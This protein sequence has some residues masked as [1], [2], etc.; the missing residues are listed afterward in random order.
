MDL[1]AGLST[2][3]GGYDSISMVVDKLTKVTHLIPVKKTFSASDIA[4]VFVK[5]IVRL[6]GFP[7]RIISDHDLK[8]KTSIRRC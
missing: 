3:S 4:T 1:E 5:E 8:L 7:R 6:H 2:V